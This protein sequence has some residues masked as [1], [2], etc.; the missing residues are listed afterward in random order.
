[1]KVVRY[2]FLERYYAQL[3]PDHFKYDKFRGGYRISSFCLCRSI[4]AS[5]EC[6]GRI[7]HKLYRNIVWILY[8]YDAWC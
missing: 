7:I 2:L 5:T 8:N 3:I 4:M 6:M 1:M